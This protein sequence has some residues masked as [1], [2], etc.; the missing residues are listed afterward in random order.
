MRLHTE[1]VKPPRALWVPFELGR[2]LG[3]PEDTAFQT[4]V[5]RSALDLLERTDGPILEDFPDDAPA[6]SSEDD[7]GWVCPI[8]LPAP[9]AERDQDS[10]LLDEIEALRSW[11]DLAVDRRGRTA[12]GTSQL[13]IEDLVRYLSAWARGETPD[14]GPEEN[15]LPT[16]LRLACDDFKAYYSEAATAQ[17]GRNGSDPS[18]NEIADWFWSQTLG[19]DMLLRLRATLS[20]NENQMVSI[21]G[22]M[23]IVPYT[24]SHR[25][26][27]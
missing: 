22:K 18:S 1:K 17:P 24:E 15:D 26:P 16:Q 3:A 19:G 20:E 27:R 8:N 2:P 5:L 14:A 13:E 12:V 9:E 23:L 10:A 4:G 11:Y 6:S 7:E 25:Q 21:T